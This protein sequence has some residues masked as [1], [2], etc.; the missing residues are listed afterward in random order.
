MHYHKKSNIPSIQ[1]CQT[2]FCLKFYSISYSHCVRSLPLFS[3]QSCNI[4]KAKHSINTSMSNRQYSIFFSVKL[5]N[6]LLALRQISFP[7]L[8]SVILPPLQYLFI[9]IQCHF[10]VL[11]LFTLYIDCMSCIQIDETYVSN[12]W[13]ELIRRSAVKFCYIRSYLFKTLKAFFLIICSFRETIQIHFNEKWTRDW[14]VILEY[15][16]KKI[17]HYARC[18]YWTLI[19][20]T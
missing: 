9:F 4:T 19:T 14:Y 5:C 8:L 18:V 1:V 12:K 15:N 10:C 11:C 20:D 2:V 13:L 7:F 6:I 16:I 3:F 17:D